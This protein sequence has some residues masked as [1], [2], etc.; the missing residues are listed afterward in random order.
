MS[1][2]L[3]QWVGRVQQNFNEFAHRIDMGAEH[4]QMHRRALALQQEQRVKTN[5]EPHCD[6]KKISEV[7]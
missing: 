5:Q 2:K 3:G 7:F 1:P 6:S 4:R